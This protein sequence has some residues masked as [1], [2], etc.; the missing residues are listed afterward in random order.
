M[1]GD[2]QPVKVL[3]CWDVQ[4]A[5]REPVSGIKLYKW[6][7][8]AWQHVSDN[9]EP[10]FYDANDWSDQT[11]EDEKNWYLSIPVADID[12][13]ADASLEH[14]ADV[15]QQRVSFKLPNGSMWSLR[16]PTARLT[17]IFV[18]ELEVRALTKRFGH[19]LLLHAHPE[20]GASNSKCAV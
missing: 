6:V 13:R 17:T 8:G 2:V 5:V 3:C 1:A 19:L 11:A 9:A 14:Q 18:K 16:F 4:G 20:S 7:S 15:L 10:E 12:T